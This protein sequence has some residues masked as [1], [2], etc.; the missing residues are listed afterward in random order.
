MVAKVQSALYEHSACVVA[1]V[2]HS[3]VRGVPCDSEGELLCPG[4]AGA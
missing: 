4:G 3:C 2:V 1:A